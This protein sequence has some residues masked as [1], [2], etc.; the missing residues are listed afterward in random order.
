MKGTLAGLMAVLAALAAALA[1]LQLLRGVLTAASRT[2]S[3]PTAPDGARES[4]LAE[5]RRLVNHLRELEFDAQTG[6]LGAADLQQLRARYEAEALAI[7][8]RLRALDSASAP[9]SV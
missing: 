2:G 6:K 1:L 4:L 3:E 5:Q 9:R 8:D 7:D